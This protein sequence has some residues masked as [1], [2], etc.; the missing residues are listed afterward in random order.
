MNKFE[1]D[2]LAKRMSDD[3]RNA[4]GAKGEDLERSVRA[5]LMGAIRETEDEAKAIA[6]DAVAKIG[7]NRKQTIDEG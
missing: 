2:S 1:I 3:M 4:F 7:Q 5:W 6:Y